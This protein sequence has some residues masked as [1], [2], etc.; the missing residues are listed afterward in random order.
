MTDSAIGEVLTRCD[1]EEVWKSFGS[2]KNRS[3]ENGWGFLITRLLWF[4]MI[5]FGA[6]SALFFPLIDT[7]D[8]TVSH[9]GYIFKAG[10]FHTDPAGI[11]AKPAEDWINAWVS[12]TCSSHADRLN[13]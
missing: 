4:L 13:F 3:W 8:G 5:T 6:A 12:Q 1:M 2:T 10:E 9:W 11:V 7:D